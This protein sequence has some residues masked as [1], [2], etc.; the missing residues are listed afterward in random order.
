MQSCA[1]HTGT[2]GYHDRTTSHPAY[3]GLTRYEGGY[4]RSEGGTCSTSKG[5]HYI[6]Q[7]HCT[8]C[9]P[10][11]AIG[12]PASY[13]RN[14]NPFQILPPDDNDD[15]TVVASNCSP[16]VPLPNLPTS[17]LPG[18]PPARRRMRQLANQPTNPPPTLQ[19]SSPLTT[20]PPRALASPSIIPAIT[21]TTPHAHIHDL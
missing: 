20:S 9:H 14:N 12:P 1:G 8:Q 17:D 15:V 7:H 6:K 4:T 18:N 16:R 13:S 19:S 5:G 3:H 10:T 11:N 21:P 2:H